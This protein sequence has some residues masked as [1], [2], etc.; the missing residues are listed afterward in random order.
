MSLH[1]AR[2]KPSVSRGRNDEGIDTVLHNLGQATHDG[3][4][5]GQA[6]SHRFDQRQAEGLVLRRKDEGV[7]GAQPVRDVV[8]GAREAHAALE[9]VLRHVT[10]QLVLAGVEV[11]AAFADE[12]QFSGAAVRHYSRQASSSRGSPL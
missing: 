11:P 8:H 4:D 2:R 6:A 10:A 12:H 3:R 5:R 7:R 9:R 1:S